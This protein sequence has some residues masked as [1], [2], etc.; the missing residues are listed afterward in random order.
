M[1][2][3]DSAVR[4]NLI[5]NNNK[6][7][8][9]FYLYDSGVDWAPTADQN[10]NVV[11]D[12]IIWIGRY[13]WQ[14]N[15]RQEPGNTEAIHFND[16]TPDQSHSMSGNI[17]R[18]NILVTWCGPTL[19]F[20]QPRIAA[21]TTIENNLIF[22]TGN[23]YSEGIS[24]ILAIG[25]DFKT[26]YTFAGFEAYSPLFHDNTFADPGFADVSVNSFTTPEKFDF[27]RAKGTG[28]V[29]IEPHG[30]QIF[31]LPLPGD[32]NLDGKVD[33]EDYK[34]ILQNFG[35]TDAGRRDGDV[36][37]D[38]DVDYEDYQQVVKDFGQK[39]E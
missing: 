34:K 29:S 32:V 4:G 19:S 13:E 35:S 5:F 15:G 8:V 37:A 6:Q 14:D 11:E 36:D 12:N 10:N 27:A 18:N 1:G 31:L 25:P 2:V 7:G 24:R 22:R 30:S 20:C 3:C 28:M 9:V 17:I 21:V 33:Y 39:E 23:E 38:G 26:C 16:S